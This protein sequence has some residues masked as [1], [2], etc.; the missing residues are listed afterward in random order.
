MKSLRNN[1]RSE[2]ESGHGHGDG[3]G[4]LESGTVPPTDTFPPHL[5]TLDIALDGGINLFF[6]WLLSYD[7]PPVF[8]SLKFGGVASGAPL[9]P[10]EAYLKH[11]S[12][13]IEPLVLDFWADRAFR[14]FI[15]LPASLG[16]HT[17]LS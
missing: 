1:Q 8:T 14:S 7:E 11:V 9:G 10:I 3:Y 15:T 2:T 5:R 12:H 16:V 13:K 17:N 6:E 4:V